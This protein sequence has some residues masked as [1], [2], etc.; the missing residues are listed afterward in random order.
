MHRAHGSIAPGAERAAVVLDD[1]GTGFPADDRQQ[2][3]FSHP[4]TGDGKFQISM[5]GKNG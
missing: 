4:T 1:H 2:G 5:V 3:L